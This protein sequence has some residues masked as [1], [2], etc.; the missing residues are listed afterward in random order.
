M[1]RYILIESYWNKVS[2]LLDGM[3]SLPNFKTFAKHYT[4][5]GKSLHVVR[6]ISSTATTQEPLSNANRCACLC[7]S[8][9]KLQYRPMTAEYVQKARLFTAN[10][11]DLKS[12][13]KATQ[14]CN[15]MKPLLFPRT[16]RLMCSLGDR[17][18]ICWNCK[19]KIGPEIFFCDICRII[20]PPLCEMSYFE[21]FER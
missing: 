21:M 19:K 2:L 11:I 7:A 4:K 10:N 6:P 17:E 15:S 20:Q 1:A 5:L 12:T 8:R 3:N 9:N 14:T 16:N 18:R 13:T